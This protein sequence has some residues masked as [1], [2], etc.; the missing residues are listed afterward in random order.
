MRDQFRDHSTVVWWNKTHIAESN[1]RYRKSVETAGPEHWARLLSSPAANKG[2]S[3]RNH[4]NE[5]ISNPWCA[6]AGCG[7]C[8]VCIAGKAASGA[9]KTAGAGTGWS[10]ISLCVVAVVGLGGAGSLGA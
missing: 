6:L 10:P 7:R 9:G 1:R 4:S 8:T 5:I 2:S 3:E